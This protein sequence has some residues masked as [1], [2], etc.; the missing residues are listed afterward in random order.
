MILHE[1]N[2]QIASV[3]QALARSVALVAPLL[4]KTVVA[5]DH[6]SIITKQVHI[7]RV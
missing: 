1:M 7:H 2:I 3:A 5:T 6:D 4:A